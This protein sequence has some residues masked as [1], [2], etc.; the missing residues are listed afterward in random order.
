[1]RCIIPKRPAD[2]PTGPRNAEA[3]GQAA[4]SGAHMSMFSKLWLGLEVADDDHDHVPVIVRRMVF[5][6]I[7][8]R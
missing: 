7:G 5:I 8:S 6:S 2:Q 1:M 3:T 4:D